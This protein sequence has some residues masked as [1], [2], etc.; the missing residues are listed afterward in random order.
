[1]QSFKIGEDFNAVNSC[2]FEYFKTLQDKTIDL[3]LTDPPYLISRDTGFSAVKNGVKRFAVSMDFGKWDKE[4]E[5]F[6]EA[7]CEMYRV[8]KQGGTCI[9]FYDL[10][11]ITTLKEIMELAG[12]KQI[13][14]IEWIKTNPVPLNSKTNYLTNAREIALLGVK[15][16]N[17]VFNSQYYNGVYSYP[18]YHSKNRFHPT[19]KPV[20]LFND[21]I[22]K[23]SNEGDIV[24]DPFF[25]SLTTGISAL[26]TGRSFTGC[27]LNNEYF[28]K[29][30]VR[31]NKELPIKFKEK[32]KIM[33]T[34]ERKTL[35]SQITINEIEDFISDEIIEN[36][37]DIMNEVF[38]DFAIKVVKVAK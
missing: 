28:A 38:K 7:V 1:M 12:F 17:P 37:Y 13:R 25:G 34:S 2:C 16:S 20:D 14:M 36:D 11:K 19:Q 15:G 3:V 6:A 22:L 9:I 30:I 23:H 29:A 24:C 32:N 18:I 10:W 26:N 21:L 33:D 27:E 8:L 31:L 4:F 35:K 5:G